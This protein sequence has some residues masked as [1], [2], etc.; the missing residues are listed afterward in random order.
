MLYLTGA[1]SSLAKSSEA[2]QNDPIKSLGGYIS[3]SPVP[4]N[5]LNGLFDMLS[6]MTLKNKQKETI[7]IALVNKFDKSVKNVKLKTL[8]NKNNIAKFKVAAVNMDKDMLMEHI[9]NR[10]DEPMQ[11]DFYDTSFTKASVELEVVAGGEI[12][13]TISLMP[14]NVTATIEN[15]GID[16]TVDAIIKAFYDN[17]NYSAIKLSNNRIYI[18]S[19]SEDVVS[20]PINCISTVVGSADIRFRGEFKNSLNNEVLL[21]ESLL[22]GEAIGLWIQR[23]IST[24]GKR[25]DE[26]I[27][28]DYNDGKVVEN[29]EGVEL[30]FNY[31]FE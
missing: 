30:I 24:T 16:G 23:S 20:K 9:N 11:A 26:E 29:V 4:N 19:K 10:Y 1:S 15:K 8:V 27:I 7:A 21:C 25:S 3:S 31:N 5:S 22:P 18:E 2:P 14:F 12:G 17:E 6:M 28:C 13:D